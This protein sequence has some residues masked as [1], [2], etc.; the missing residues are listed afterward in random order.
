MAW[1]LLAVFPIL[2]VRNPRSLKATVLG[3]RK[4]CPL[5]PEHVTAPPHWNKMVREEEFKDEGW[6]GLHNARWPQGKDS[7]SIF[8]LPPGNKVTGGGLADGEPGFDVVPTL[9]CLGP[10]KP[11]EKR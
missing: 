2:I 6:L 9:P 11:K 1:F 3:A 10:F 5:S 7:R 4:I 8:P